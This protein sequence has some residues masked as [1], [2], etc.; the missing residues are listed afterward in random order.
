MKTMRSALVGD[1][2]CAVAGWIAEDAAAS[3]ILHQR[4]VGDDLLGGATVHAS[5]TESFEGRYSQDEEQIKRPAFG[6]FMQW[7]VLM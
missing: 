5:P 7:S 4:A 6:L 3:R 1:D 2:D